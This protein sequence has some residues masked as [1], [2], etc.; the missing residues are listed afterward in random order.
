M[1]S[2][3]HTRPPC[4]SPTPGVHPNPCLLS[5]QCHPTISSS[6][7]PFS[8]CPQSFPASGSFQMSQLC[9]SGGQ[10][11]GVS[12]STSA[13]PDLHVPKHISW[14]LGRII[15]HKA[16][17]IIKCWLSHVIYWTLYWKG[18]TDVCWCTDCSPSWS[19]TDWELWITATTQHH[20]R[21][22]GSTWLDPDSKFEISFW[23]MRTQHS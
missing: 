14:Q 7:I 11:I 8:S 15:Q 6:V 4:P 19:H 2:S 22:C 20:E 23:W 10:S 5:Q 21:E 17:F 16:Y 1:S 18:R 9:A 12:A 13:K 3:L